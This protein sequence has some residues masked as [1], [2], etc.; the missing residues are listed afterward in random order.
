VVGGLTETG[1]AR[2]D[3]GFDRERTVRARGA[4]VHHEQF[5]GFALQG[6]QLL[7]HRL[8]GLSDSSW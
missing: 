2:G 8:T 7:V 1:I 4:A 5:H 3:Q 6:F